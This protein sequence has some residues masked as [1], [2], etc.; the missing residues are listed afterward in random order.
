M[1]RAARVLGVGLRG[2]AASQ[3]QTPASVRHR[4]ARGRSERVPETG[5]VASVQEAEVTM[6]AALLDEL[7]KP[8]VP[9][10]AG[11]RLLA[12]DQPGDAEPG[13]GRLRART[14]ARSVLLTRRLPLLG[15]RAPEYETSAP[16]RL[17]DL[18]DQPRGARR[19]R[20]PRPRAFCGS[21]VQPARARPGGRRPRPLGPARGPQLLSLAARLGALRPLRRLA[22]R[23]D[24]AADPRAH[25][26]RLPALARAARPAA[27]AG[28]RA[29]RRDRRRRRRRSADR[30]D[31][32][33]REGGPSR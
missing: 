26:Q 10:A 8:G 4:R 29:R 24:P 7:W 12:L 27:V 11:A 3:E 22:L 33:G 16:T 15:F 30:F 2:T 31:R 23:P 1:S 9:G 25:L 19:P 20:G 17:R 32:G 5:A 6:P 21:R 28:R 18:A 14:R 13:P